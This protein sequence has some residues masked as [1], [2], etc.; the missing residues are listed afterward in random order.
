[1]RSVLRSVAY[2]AK[3]M[4]YVLEE[5]FKCPMPGDGHDFIFSDGTKFPAFVYYSSLNVM[6]FHPD[7]LPKMQAD[8]ARNG[9]DLQ[10]T[11]REVFEEMKKQRQ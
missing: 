4:L 8:S 6:V 10:E 9:I 2:P 1:M 3:T 5:D 11:S 7:A